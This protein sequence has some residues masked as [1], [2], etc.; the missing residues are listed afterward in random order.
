MTFSHFLKYHSHFCY[1]DFAFA[2]PCPWTILAQVLCVSQ[3]KFHIL[4]DAFP[5]SPYLRM[6]PVTTHHSASFI[7]FI[8]FITVYDYFVCLIID[9][10]H[11]KTNT[12]LPYFQHLAKMK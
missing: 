9:C 1:G 2:L 4:K 11:M 12:C 6:Y 5:D 7:P 8:A 3:L 10:S